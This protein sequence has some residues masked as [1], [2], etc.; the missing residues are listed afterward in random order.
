MME[1]SRIRAAERESEDIVAAGLGEPAPVAR[2]VSSSERPTV[3]ERATL[4]A[5]TIGVVMGVIIF[6][7]AF[8]IGV[9][10][11][12]E[13]SGALNALERALW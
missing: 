11:L 5:Q 1:D 2:I 8:S 6:A 10:Q 3:L 13:W 7:A 12:M 9:W 4:V